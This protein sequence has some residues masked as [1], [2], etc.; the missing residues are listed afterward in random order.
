[1]PTFEILN[2]SGQSVG[3]ID[4]FNYIWNRKYFEAGDF[5]IDAPATQINID[6]LIAKNIVLKP[7]AVESGKIYSVRSNTDENG[8]R[9]I[10]AAGRFLSYMLK[11]HSI[12]YNFSFNGN[13]AQAMRILVDKTV[14]S[15]AADD[16]IDDLIITEDDTTA[17]FEGVIKKYTDLY[18]ALVAIAYASGVGFKIAYDVDQAK[19]IFSCYEAADRS[20]DQTV[21]PVVEFS[22]EYDNIGQ[23]EYNIDTDAEVNAV[24]AEYN[25]NMGNVVVTY[26]P[27]GA[28]GKDKREIHITG[29]CVTQ[30]AYRV[31]GDGSL[32][33]YDVVDL[34]ETQKSLLAL[35]KAAITG[36]AESFTGD[37]NTAVTSYIYKT[38]YDIGDIVTV[39]NLKIGKTITQRITEICEVYDENGT[40]IDVACGSRYPVIMDILKKK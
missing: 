11:K 5:E 23:S 37:I 3:D 26:N 29:D 1:M 35:A 36:S 20:I 17:T 7:G 31:K 12:K 13:A 6:C 18:D 28:T 33:E 40:I 27:T 24:I 30:K 10:T 19:Y 21:N 38:D 32:E 15:G 34:V 4:E 9:R 22:E 39:T 14:I 16:I 2:A 25:G 8:D